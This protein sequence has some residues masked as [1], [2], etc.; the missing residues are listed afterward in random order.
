[1]EERPLS[2][3]YL[4]SLTTNELVETAD[5]LGMDVTNDPDRLSIIE[6]LLEIA[7]GDPGDN[8][9]SILSDFHL[10]DS[11]PLP[12]QYNITFIDVM[13][14]DPL[15]AFVFWEIKA[16]DKEQFEKAPDFTGYYLKVSPSSASSG[17]NPIQASGK[18]EADKVF[19]VSVSPNDTAWYLGLSPAAS[20]EI[21]SLEQIPYKVELCAGFGYKMEEGTEMVLAASAPVRLPGLPEMPKAKLQGEN[22]L[23][24]LSG[25]GDFQVI[26]RN[27]RPPR[28]K[29]GESAGPIE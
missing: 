14:R 17:K 15:W 4:E 16:Q 10:L 20:E 13:I 24:R 3:A 23:L 8:S 29:R 6:E 5:S 11:V 2:R 25:Y 1:M 22:P 9:N 19:S 27:E 21:S 28:I 7:S 18:A 26:R 12:K